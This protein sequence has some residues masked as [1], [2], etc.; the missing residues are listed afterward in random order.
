MSDTE[1]TSKRGRPAKKGM[2]YFSLDTKL[3]I[4]VEALE[5]D[6]GNDGFAVYIK[7][8]QEI[9]QTEEGELDISSTILRRVLA[10]KVNMTEERWCEIIGVAVE[11][12]LFNQDKFGAQILTSNGVKRRYELVR[13]T[14]GRARSRM[15]KV[16]ESD[17]PKYN[18]L[19]NC[20]R[21]QINS[22]GQQCNKQ[23]KTKLNK[24]ENNACASETPNGARALRPE[25]R[26]F[27]RSNS[28]TNPLTNALLKKAGI[29]S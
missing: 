3:D 21:E 13:N 5:S 10:K 9:Y 16:R 29:T 11:L 20:S 18:N 27:S 25:R 12:G 19:A 2:E 28:D 15:N 22:S 26:I 24:K 23:N 14:R 8:L 6:F 4:K 7:T 1:E 17:E